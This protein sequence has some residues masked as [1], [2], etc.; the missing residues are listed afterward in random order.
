MVCDAQSF[1]VDL[2]L[3][4][5]NDRGPCPR[6]HTRL[7]ILRGGLGLCSAYS[8]ILR[9]FVQIRP[10]GYL[11]IGIVGGRLHGASALILPQLYGS[12]LARQVRLVRRNIGKL[13]VCWCA[14]VSFSY[15][16]LPIVDEA[17][18]SGKFDLEGGDGK[19]FGILLLYLG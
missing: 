17:G 3:K 9:Q 15:T 19:V 16:A 7:Q 2:D 8:G 13:E 5:K 10:V 4:R 1:L 6:D 11:V 18:V 14:F 12:A